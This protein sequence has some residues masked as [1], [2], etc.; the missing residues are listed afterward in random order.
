MLFGMEIRVHLNGVDMIEGKIKR[1]PNTFLKLLK[2][3]ADFLPMFFSII[4]AQIKIMLFWVGIRIEFDKLKHYT[5]EEG[6][7]SKRN[8][9]NGEEI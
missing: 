5:P 7:K 3:L 6:F 1:F 4:H 9:G 8:N 2:N